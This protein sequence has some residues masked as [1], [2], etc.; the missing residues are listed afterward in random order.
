MSELKKELLAPC[1]LYCG[2]CSIYIAHRDNN[3]KFKKALLPVYKAF[4]KSVED[5]SCTGCLSDGIIFPV[6]KSCPIKKCSQKKDIEGCYQ[7]EE[8]PCRFIENFPVE[9][10]KKVMM[11][12]IP[13]WREIGTE[14]FVESEEKRYL[15]PNCGNPLFRGVKKCNECNIEVDLD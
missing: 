2:V 9:R 15:C 5:I 11:R 1:G 13:T 3:I 4:A 14:K 12:T 10:A 6:C 8:W 7:C